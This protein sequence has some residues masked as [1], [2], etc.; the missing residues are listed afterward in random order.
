MKSNNALV[1]YTDLTTMGLLQQAGTN[2]PIGN[3]M[4]TKSFINTYYHANADSLAVYANNQLPP[5]QKITPQLTPFL[6]CYNLTIN[7]S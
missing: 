6:F 7:T 2:P 1:T 3:R 5:Y 4:A